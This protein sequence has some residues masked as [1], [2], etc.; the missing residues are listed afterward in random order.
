MVGLFNVYN[1]LAALGVALEIGVP[2]QKA[3]AAIQ[4]FSGVEGRMQR[5]DHKGIT[6]Y[7]D[8][9]HTPD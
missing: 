8:F 7:I 9:A 1:I 4:E 6:A 5:I 2:V 3:I